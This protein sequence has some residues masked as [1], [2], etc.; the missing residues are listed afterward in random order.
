MAGAVDGAVG[1]TGKA[2]LNASAFVY[3]LPFPCAKHKSIC[4]GTASKVT[5]FV[6][7]YVATVK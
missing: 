5:D 3:L 1:R 4:G 2:V 7:I 6:Y